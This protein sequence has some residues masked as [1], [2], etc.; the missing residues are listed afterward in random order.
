MTKRLEVEFSI[1]QM[2]DAD[3]DLFAKKQ[4]NAVY[5]KIADAIVSL[6]KQKKVNEN[7]NIEVGKLS[8]NQVRN[9]SAQVNRALETM[10][11]TDYKT[12]YAIRENGSAM[13]GFV[14]KV[15]KSEE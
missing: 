10:K 3:K 13:L 4:S 5:S 6:H 9:L 15:V 12:R 1:G 14:K 2:T 8:E 7:T 11:F